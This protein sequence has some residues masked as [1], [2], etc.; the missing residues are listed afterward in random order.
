MRWLAL[1]AVAVLAAACGGDDDERATST[2]GGLR[3]EVA[4]DEPV[5]VGPV[6][7]VVEVVNDG[8]QDAVL[9]FRNS[10][11]AEVTLTQDGEELYRWSLARMF[12]Q[13]LGEETV[14]AGRERRFVL[15][16]QLEVEPGEY[17]LTATLTAAE[18]G[19]LRASRSITVRPRRR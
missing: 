19:E 14:A 18:A 17:E 13:Q 9:S 8:D 1:L 3:L 12:S 15:E 7:W 2:D 11:R 5:H 4:V 6:R 10:Q 16:D